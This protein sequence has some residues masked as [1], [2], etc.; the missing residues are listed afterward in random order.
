M[1]CYFNGAPAL[2][3]LVTYPYTSFYTIFNQMIVFFFKAIALVQWLCIGWVGPSLLSVVHQDA[4]AFTTV[5]VCDQI[6]KHGGP[7]LHFIYL[8]TRAKPDR[9]PLSALG[10]HYKAPAC[11]SSV[12]SRSVLFTTSFSH[13]LQTTGGWWQRLGCWTNNLPLAWKWQTSLR[14]WHWSWSDW[15]RTC[16]Q[17]PHGVR[18][19]TGALWPG[20]LRYFTSNVSVSLSV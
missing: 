8:F 10:I 1:K 18:W 2:S 15:M 7:Y 16:V 20:I 9:F 4:L 13:M 3:E 11:H 6:T 19:T 5:T 12:H 17:Q 14:L